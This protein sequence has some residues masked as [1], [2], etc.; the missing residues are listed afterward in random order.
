MAGWLKNGSRLE[1]GPPSISCLH[2]SIRTQFFR[3]SLLGPLTQLLAILYM[4][5]TK[6]LYPKRTSNLRTFTLRALSPRIEKFKE[7]ISTNF[8]ID[9]FHWVL[10]IYKKESVFIWSR[11]SSNTIY[12]RNFWTDDQNARFAFIYWELNPFG[13]L[14]VLIIL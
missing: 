3:I 6:P 14:V 7:Y 11:L 12:G 5:C 10:V 2:S 1:T 13:F 4:I 8:L 9:E